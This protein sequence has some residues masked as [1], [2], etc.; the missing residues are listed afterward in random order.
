MTSPAD[1]ARAPHARARGAQAEDR[2]VRWLAAQGYRVVERNL[3]TA[4]GE[5][6]AVAWDG[7]V[8][9]F[10]EIKARASAQAGSALDAVD[11]R[12]QRR[13][14]RAAS[15]YLA[16]LGGEP[17]CRFD[18]LALDLDGGAWAFTLVRDAFQLG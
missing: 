12:K 1:F 7:D 18:V 11:P 2:A 8:L 9:C 5:L 10:I 6:D 15:L 16:R 17:A 13:L 3:V 4:A 14:G